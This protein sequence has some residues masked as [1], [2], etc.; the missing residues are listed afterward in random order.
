[1]VRERLAHVP[2]ALVYLAIAISGALA[3]SRDEFDRIHVRLA[4]GVVVFLLYL[5]FH[6]SEAYA[7]Y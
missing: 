6:T 2:I 1:M 7:W 3:A 4:A 5:A